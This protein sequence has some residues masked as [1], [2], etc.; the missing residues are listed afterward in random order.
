MHVIVSRSA[1]LE[2]L[3][4][5][6]GV[7]ATRSTKE[8]LKCVRLTTK[9]NTL[10]VSATDLEVAL[11]VEVRQVEVK[12]KGDLLIPA[13][14]LMSIARESV[15][16]TLTIEADDQACHIRGKDSHFEVYGQDPRDFPPVPGLEG[17]PDLEVD[18]PVLAD[19]ISKTLFSVAKENTRYAI[20]GILWQKL[21]KK[22]ILVSTDGRRLAR[23]MGAAEG[24]GA[25][26][27]MIVPAKT[28]QVLQ[29]VLGHIE[30][31][32]GVKFSSN[33]IVVQAD[34][35]VVSSALVEGHFPQ[36]EDVIPKDS[37]KKV[38]LNTEELLSAVKRAALL[39]NE[40][41]KGVRLRF[42]KGQLVLSSRA[43]EQGEATIS[44][45]VEYGGTPVEIGFNPLFLMDALRVAASPT[46]TL[47]MK[48]G[49]R[50]G[51]FRVGQTFL[52][53]VMPVNLA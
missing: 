4:A 28:V 33:Q 51:I 50:P 25:D 7:A 20:N 35:Y 37:D 44:M 3:G 52:Y 14:K 34:S 48:D 36:Y 38:D 41:S 9:D 53:V 49:N 15:D 19:L 6:S 8:V 5:A 42:E 26:S 18:A 11:R 23:S 45:Q 31:K 12:K 1:L 47:E 29:R 40:Q 46:I 39:T 32:A 24:A 13:D 16:D 30:G 2:V 21:G 43:P 10:V 22:L 27:Q 17:Q